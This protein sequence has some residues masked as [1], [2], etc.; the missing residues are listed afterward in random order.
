MSQHETEEDDLFTDEV[1]N[2][3]GYAEYDW[4]KLPEEEIELHD[5]V[6]DMDQ[7]E[8]EA[9]D[10]SKVS[11]L[12]KWAAAQSWAELDES[13]RFQ[14][15]SAELID[16]TNRHPALD[17][18]EIGI[19]LLNDFLVEERFEDARTLL[20]KVA[21]MVP[22]DPHVKP[23]FTAIIDVLSGNVEDGMA[24]FQ[25]M[26]DNAGD[27]AMLVLVIA[28]DLIAVDKL[29]EAAQVLDKAEEL[30]RFT[31]DDEVLAAVEDARAF[32]VEAKNA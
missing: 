25:N 13:D 15:I 31:Q 11:D 12:I 6:I 3:L 22:D 24:A 17:Y 7:A 28:E 16:S 29:E 18:G 14:A 19:E 21:A 4:D 1:T 23:R 9:L 26:I 30:A 8:L 20:V 2:E 32:L 27:D 10:L 5:R